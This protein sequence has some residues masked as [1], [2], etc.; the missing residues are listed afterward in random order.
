MYF[1]DEKPYR[2]HG[3]SP[4]I[5]IYVLS[6]DGVEMDKWSCGHCK[7][8]LFDFKGTINNIIN[9]PMPVNEFDIAINTRCKLCKQNYRLLINSAETHQG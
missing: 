7:R 9:T 8:T 2:D 5:S 3:D 6:N 1:T 4:A